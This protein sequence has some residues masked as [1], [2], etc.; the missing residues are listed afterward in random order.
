MADVVLMGSG[1]ASWSEFLCQDHT[2][3]RSI[4]RHVYADRLPPARHQPGAQGRIIARLRLTREIV[5]EDRHEREIS[6]RSS[7]FLSVRFP[8]GFDPAAIALA[9][10]FLSPWPNQDGGRLSEPRRSGAPGRT[11]TCGPELRRLV[12]YPT[13][14]RARKAF[15][16]VG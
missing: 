5:N 2:P 12:L 9:R 11:R 1:M 7:I 15:P 6:R 16:I 3:R 13:E 8:V 4:G 10:R 14:L